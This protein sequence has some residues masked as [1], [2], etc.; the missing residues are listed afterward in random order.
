LAS[1]LFRRGVVTADA[2]LAVL[3]ATQGRE[4]GRAS[5]VTTTLNVAGGDVVG[6]QVE[7]AAV[8]VLS[9]ELILSEP[10]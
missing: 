9:G 10:E 1:F 7:G 3:D 4:M 8:R 2:G 5:R 6:V